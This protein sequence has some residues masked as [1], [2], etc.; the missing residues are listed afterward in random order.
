[1]TQAAATGRAVFVNSAW[2]IADKVVRMGLSLIVTVWLARQFGPETF[3][4]WNYAMAFA[5]F[6]GAFASLGLDSVVH[7]P[8]REPIQHRPHRPPFCQASTTSASMTKAEIHR[9]HHQ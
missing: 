9:A 6:F 7:K 8:P 1:M 5:A 3:G 4:V 2:L